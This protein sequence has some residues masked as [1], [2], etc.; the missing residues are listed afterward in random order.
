MKVM[1]QRVEDALFLSSRTFATKSAR[2]RSAGSPSLHP[3]LNELRTC[4]CT[5]RALQPTTTFGDEGGWRKRSRAGWG[6]PSRWENQKSIGVTPKNVW[7]WRA[8][9][10]CRKPELRSSIWRMSDC[11]WPKMPKSKEAELKKIKLVSS[12]ENRRGPSLLRPS[13]MPRPSSSELGG[14]ARSQPPFLRKFE[15]FF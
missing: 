4:G 11:A 9:W 2:T 5:Q 15:E 13:S 1:L 12:A 3:H 10:G 8:A 7:N 6:S 14:G